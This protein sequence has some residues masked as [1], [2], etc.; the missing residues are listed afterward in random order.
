MIHLCILLQS[1]WGLSEPL[2]INTMI[3]PQ[4]TKTKIE[5][6]KIVYWDWK[7]RCV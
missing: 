2:A 3:V 1:I 7:N 5:K 6:M 4:D